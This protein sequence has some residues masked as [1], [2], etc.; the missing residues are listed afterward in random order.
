MDW[1]FLQP[2][3]I[4]L[5][6][7]GIFLRLLAKEKHRR[8]KHLQYRLEEHVR[9]LREEQE[10]ARKAAGEAVLESGEPADAGV[11]AAAPASEP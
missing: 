8:E 7:T 2:T 9:K 4:L 6:G 3:L 5:V 10:K 11:V 1:S